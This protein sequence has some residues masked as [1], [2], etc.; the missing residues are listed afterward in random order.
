MYLYSYL[1]SGVIYDAIT[2][3]SIFITS[4]STALPSTQLPD[5]DFADFLSACNSSY[6]AW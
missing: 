4:D 5:I 3:Q 2:I 1:T 6:S